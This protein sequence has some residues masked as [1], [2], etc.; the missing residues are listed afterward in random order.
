MTAQ[1]P[2]EELVAHRAWLAGVV[3]RWVA[4]RERADDLL[5]DVWLQVLRRPPP[6][7]SALRAWLVAVARNRWRTMRRREAR[8][9]RGEHEVARRG[10]QAAAETARHEAR[11]ER[12]GAALLQLEEPYRSALIERYLEGRSPREIAARHRRPVRTVHSHLERGLSMLRARLGVPPPRRRRHVG[13]VWPWFARRGAAGGRAL[14]AA[15]GLLS[16]AAVVLVSMAAWRDEPGLSA[17]P[18][19]TTSTARSSP[20]AV[21]ATPRRSALPRAPTSGRSA[22]AAN[23]R[24]VRGRV[25]DVQGRP[26][27]DARVR[28]VPGRVRSVP[29]ASSFFEP[30]RDA[31]RDASRDARDGARV[32]CDAQGDFALDLPYAASGQLLAERPGWTTA[33]GS[34]VG[35]A[36][37]APRTLIVAPTR[38]IRGRVIAPDGRGVASARVRLVHTERCW[39]GLSLQLHQPYGNF[40]SAESEEDGRFVLPEA[41]WLAGAELEVVADQFEPKNAAVAPFTEVRLEPLALGEARVRGRVLDG[42]GAP[43][44][45]AV[46]ALGPRV[47]RTAKDGRFALLLPGFEHVD[48]IHA[49]APGLLPVTAVR[50]GDEPWPE[51]VTLTLAE[52]PREIRGVVV[53]DRGEPVAKA[54]VWI[55]DPTVLGV[56]HRPWVAE[57]L[58]AGRR[59]ELLLRTRSDA[60][61][62]FTLGGLGARPYRVRALVRKTLA[63]VSVEAVPNGPA[64]RL[65]IPTDAVASEISG[66]ATDRDGA[67]LAGVTVRAA[68]TAISMRI[69]G[70]DGKRD[71]PFNFTVSG[72]TTRTDVT[73][74]FRL[75]HVATDRVTL[76]LSAPGRLRARHRLVAP[77]L[78]PLRIVVP[79]EAMLRVTVTHPDQHDEFG[80]VDAGGRPLW[81]H[82]RVNATRTAGATA[83][84][85]ARRRPLRIGVPEIVVV[86]DHAHEVRLYRRGAETA[87][88]PVRLKAGVINTVT[89]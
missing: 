74:R 26:V 4:D 36:S 34:L 17:R 21:G 66:L 22:G 72:P 23:Q 25:V 6:A 40:P 78:E 49:A 77:T 11:L 54:M 53:D 55:E 28:F 80:V 67:P 86:P 37:E 87:R 85:R 9:R 68:A 60:A 59:E 48:R 70:L 75:R 13:L 27:L 88:I 7:G 33:V 50:P 3:R 57:A 15:V 62:G 46:V 58:V 79:G 83:R 84:P 38:K 44:A 12:V 8:Q 31:S 32:A 5:Q 10:G 64:V 82:P 18:T 76:H 24:H 41:Y 43:F 52:P 47:A 56:D 20:A 42:A 39:S 29:G 89:G 1:P 30:R 19:V 65:Q 63:S 35:T 81:L 51:E 45:G 73:G 61:G 71:Q 69:D 16:A 2:D 14:R